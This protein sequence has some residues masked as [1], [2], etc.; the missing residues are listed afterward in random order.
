MRDSI[1]MDKHGN[2][3]SIKNKIHFWFYS[4]GWITVPGS[5]EIALIDRLAQFCHES[6]HQQ[7]PIGRPLSPFR[8]NYNITKN[9]LLLRG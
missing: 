1:R 6:L 7:P 3:L 8:S 5:L 2:S 9:G 4:N